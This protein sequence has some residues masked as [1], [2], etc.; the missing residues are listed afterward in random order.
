MP[1]SRK[2]LLNSSVQKNVFIRF[3]EE[4]QQN[5]IGVIFFFFSRESINEKIVV[6]KV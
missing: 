4:I 3:S 5:M 6:Q 1:F 2:V